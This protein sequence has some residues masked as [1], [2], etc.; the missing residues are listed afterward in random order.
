VE[1]LLKT[2]T[3]A[4]AGLAVNNNAAAVLLALASVA[5]GKE[6]IVSRGQAVE[7]GGHFRIP[8]VLRQSGCRLV[9]VGTTNRTRLADYEEAITPRTAALL[10]VH[11]SNFRVVGFTEEVGIVE[12]AALGR[13][14]GLTVLD[15]L[16]SGALLDTAK[17]GLAHE[18][19]VQESVKA[20]VDLVCF[21]GDK[22]LGGPQAGLAVGRAELVQRLKRHPLA[23]AVRV[24]KCSLAALAAT[25]VH[26]V[27]GEAET[28]IPVWQMIA[29]SSDEAARSA[30]ALAEALTVAGIAVEVKE[31]R[32]TV[33]GGSLPGETLPTW[34]VAVK[35]GGRAGAGISQTA[36]AGAL[37][38]RLRLGKPPVIARV[39]R[40]QVMLDPRTLLP[41]QAGLVAEAVIR[42]EGAGITSP[43]DAG[44]QR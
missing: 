31:G 12:L 28:C 40:G 16:G 21:S 44:A 29:M 22:L 36:A 10:H 4:E 5:R 41:G 43:A 23:R 3:G 13:S 18:P 30:G 2:L 33:G 42:A 24:D 39:E 17:Y 20:G 35:P 14:R 37:A 34:L 15:D 1:R 19:M 6:V 25:L 32:S 26:Y 11:T 8:E 38:R 7:I 27:M 9:E